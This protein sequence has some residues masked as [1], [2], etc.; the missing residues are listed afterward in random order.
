MAGQNSDPVQINDAF[1]R[2]NLGNVV[3]NYAIVSIEGNQSSGK[4]KRLFEAGF[5]LHL[6]L[7]IH[8]HESGSLLNG[9]FGTQFEV[10]DPAQMQQ[11]TKGK[12]NLFDPFI[13]SCIHKG[14]GIWMAPVRGSNMIV[15]DAEGSDSRERHTRG[16]AASER[17]TLA[18]TL[19]HANVLLINIWKQQVRAFRLL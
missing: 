13:P 16:D 5:P 3:S 9:L 6:H 19:V 11:T 8:A 4:S 10:M 12:R 7:F 2:W 17:K 1:E 18:F 15:L 14:K